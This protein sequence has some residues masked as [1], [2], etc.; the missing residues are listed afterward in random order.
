MPL[1]IKVHLL[2]NII[3]VR[4]G[5]RICEK[6]GGGPGIQIPRCRVRKLKKSAKK[7]KIGQKNKNRPKKDIWW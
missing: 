6:G 4:G 1:L 7:T 5:S 2:S 3:L